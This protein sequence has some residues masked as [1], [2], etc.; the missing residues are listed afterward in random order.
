MI[1]SKDKFEFGKEEVEFAGIT[2]GKDGIK[3]T[4]KYLATFANFPTPTNIHEIR[5]WFG[6]INQVNYCFATSGV[7]APFCHLL[8]PK[9]EFK[10]DDSLEEAFMA[11]K[12]E[13]VRLIK[14]GVK[15]FD[16]EHTTCL[17]PD[18]SKTGMGW[19]RLCFGQVLV[20]TLSTLVTR[21]K[22]ASE[23]RPPNLLGFQYHPHHQIT[24]FKW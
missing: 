3:P 4:E 5:S 17:S 24:H 9:N 23:R 22:L 16:P 10:V 14:S 11:S 8:S 20:W 21:V 15:D 7:M 6:L 19:S 13:I 18:Y 12:K 1:F 2:I